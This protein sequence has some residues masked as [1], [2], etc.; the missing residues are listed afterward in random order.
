MVADNGRELCSKRMADEE[1]RTDA[2]EEIAAVGP[3]GKFQA[4]GVRR[5]RDKGRKE[6]LKDRVAPQAGLHLVSVDFNGTQHERG[7]LT[8]GH[9]VWSLD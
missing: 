1:G 5:Q 9:C 2:A 7:V 3:H 4:G 8:P 6:S